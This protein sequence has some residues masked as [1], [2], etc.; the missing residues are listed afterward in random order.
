MS[1]S[2][3]PFDLFRKALAEL[4]AKVEEEVKA[5]Q[6][7]YGDSWYYTD[8]ET[9]LHIVKNDATRLLLTKST[10]T[11]RHRL[12]DVVAYCC[13]L[14]AKTLETEQAKALTNKSATLE[15]LHGAVP[16]WHGE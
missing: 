16:E 12:I 9:L 8:N 13:F 2:S 1:T 3:K 4:M 7:V 11:L 14:Y 10:E 6:K 5:K 15:Q